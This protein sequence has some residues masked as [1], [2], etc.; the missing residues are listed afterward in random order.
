[1]GD[2]LNK[3]DG[4]NL[5]ELD[6]IKNYQRFLA[7][8]RDVVRKARRYNMTNTEIWNIV[9]T[10]KK[11]KVSKESFACVSND[12][13]AK[14][15]KRI[16]HSLSEGIVSDRPQISHRET[17]EDLFLAFDIL[18]YMTFCQNEAKELDIFFENLLRIEQ[19]STILQATINTLK[20]D[21]EQKTTETALQHLYDELTVMMDLRLSQ[22]LV[23]I[24]ESDIAGKP[25]RISGEKFF[26]KRD[27]GDISQLNM[28]DLK[29]MAIVSN[30]P[31]SIYDQQS[32]ISPSTFIPFCS[33]GSQLI[34]TEGA[35]L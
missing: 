23:A 27:P 33:F 5:V 7:N 29:S 30:H 28:T 31:L 14:S 35:F 9:K 24:R 8:V 25:S 19:P 12:M 32:A 26:I 4:N 21:H 11:R 16:I 10:T 15:I 1:M 13:N 18:S 17:N 34:G 22:I 6:T 2:V 20:I 3:M